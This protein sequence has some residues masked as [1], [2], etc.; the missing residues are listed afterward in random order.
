MKKI[1]AKHSSF[2]EAEKADIAFYRSLSGSKKLE[3]LL[4]LIQQTLSPH[5]AAEGFK[6]VYRIVK[7]PQR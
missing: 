6:R 4:D 1:V 2:E 5:E 3:L 7:L